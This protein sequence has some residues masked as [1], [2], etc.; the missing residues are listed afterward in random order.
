MDNFSEL[1]DLTGKNVDK[2][3]VSYSNFITTFYTKI[4]KNHETPLKGLTNFW[5]TFYKKIQDSGNTSQS[6]KCDQDIVLINNS[7]ESNIDDK[8]KQTFIVIATFM[9]NNII[10]I[11]NFFLQLATKDNFQDI[12]LLH[13]NIHRWETFDNEYQNC[14]KKNN[15]YYLIEFIKA[16]NHICKR[17]RTQSD[18]SE[19]NA[20][21][22]IGGYIVEKIKEIYLGN[23]RSDEIKHEEQKLFDYA[24][25]KKIASIGD[26][27][28]SRGNIDLIKYGGKKSGKCQKLFNQNTNKKIIS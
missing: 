28:V 2:I 15:D 27:L 5:E 20:N 7:K 25:E 1:S 9:R 6:I 12:N 3:E 18:E 10:K 14:I 16:I 4:Q 8:T 22:I 17:R 11:I 26:I 21:Y 24:F 19:T 13:V 23:L